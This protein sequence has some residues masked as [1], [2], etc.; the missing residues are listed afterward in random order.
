MPIMY[1]DF[2]CDRPKHGGYVPRF[3]RP[4]KEVK[5]VSVDSLT[6]S[7]SDSDYHVD[8]TANRVQVIPRGNVVQ[9]VGKHRP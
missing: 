7:E 6:E 1:K 8:R 3:T 5:F 2:L 9:V 4:A